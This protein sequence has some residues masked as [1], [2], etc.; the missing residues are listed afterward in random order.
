CGKLIRLSFKTPDASV[1]QLSELTFEVPARRDRSSTGKR[2]LKDYPR[3]ESLR[4]P[5]ERAILIFT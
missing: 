3:V 5:G 1:L 2:F 4:L